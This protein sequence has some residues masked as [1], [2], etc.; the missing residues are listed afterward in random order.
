MRV[1]EITSLARCL[2]GGECWYVVAL[3]SG[4]LTWLALFTDG[5]SV[6]PRMQVS[7]VLAT[8]LVVVKTSHAY[9]ASAGEEESPL[10]VNLLV[11]WEADGDVVITSQVSTARRG[12][13]W[14]DSAVPR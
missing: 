4:I 3:C 2:T 6:R 7:E 5:A 12:E 14:G 10:F 11:G 8:S 13:C 1:E 9:S